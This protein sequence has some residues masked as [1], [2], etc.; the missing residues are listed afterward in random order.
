MQA[1]DGSDSA[2]KWR[3]L[4]NSSLS[5]LIRNLGTLLHDE[6]V[7]QM[8]LRI[9]TSHC[10][11]GGG[12]QLKYGNLNPSPNFQRY[13]NKYFHPFCKDAIVS[14]LAVGFVPYR[15]RKN[16]KGAKVPEVLPLG[17]Y[18]WYV[19]RS[20]QTTIGTPWNDI[21]KPPPSENVESESSDKPL[22]KYVVHSAYCKEDIQVYPFVNPQILFSCTSPLSSLIQPYMILCHKR[23]CT[24]RADGFN[25][26]PSLVLEHQDKLLINDVSNS[27]MAIQ[28]TKDMDNKSNFDYRTMGDRQNMIHTLIEESKC[29]SHL[30]RDSVSFVAPKNHSVHGLDKVLTPQDLLKDELQFNRLV[31]MACGIPISLLMQGCQSLGVG[32]GGGSKEGWAENTE[33]SNRVLL[34]TCK[35]I[36]CHLEQLLQQIH[37]SIYGEDLMPTFCIPVIPV[38]PFEQLLLAYDNMLIDDKNLSMILQS[39][40][41]FSLSGDAMQARAEK[42]KAEYVLP[43]RDKK[44][45]PKKTKKKS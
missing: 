5:E 17:T 29:V 39:C 31:G 26:Q 10:L 13:L 8:A 32:S 15:I 41:G 35:N 11:G 1:L 36:N 4:N 34:D 2:A 40:W 27:G 38:I 42:R 7:V 20:S 28:N 16:E 23:D 21:G 44:E 14:Y 22:L 9:L 37:G 45:D 19:A 3:A 18:T 25:S 43:F 33:A 24:I 12:V 30:P 6:P